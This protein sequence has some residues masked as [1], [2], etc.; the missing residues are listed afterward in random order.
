[1]MAVEGNLRFDWWRTHRKLLI[2]RKRC[3]ILS[4]FSKILMVE[5]QMVE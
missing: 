3:L 4:W 1:M 2:N 5:L